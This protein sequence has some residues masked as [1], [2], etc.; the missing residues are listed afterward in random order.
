M[1]PSQNVKSLIAIGSQSI[2]NTA[3]AGNAI[4][5]RGFDYATFHIGVICATSTSI[6]SSISVQQAD[7]TEATS[8]SA[9]AGF[10]ITSGLPTAVNT[11]TAVTNSYAVIGIDTRARKRYLRLSIIGGTSANTTTACCVLDNGEAAPTNAAAAGARYF[12]A[13]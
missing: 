7:D 9:I 5:T 8:F 10:P 13:V 1:N 11:S 3:V 6:P 12:T 2:L 4:D